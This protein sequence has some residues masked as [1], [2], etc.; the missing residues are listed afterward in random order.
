M[1]SVSLML[2]CVD[3]IVNPYSYSCGLQLQAQCLVSKV[4]KAFQPVIQ[5]PVLRI[6]HCLSLRQTLFAHPPSPSSSYTGSSLLLRAPPR[7]SNPLAIYGPTT[8]IPPTN[9]AIVAKKSPNNTNIPY[10]SMMNPKNAQRMRIS[11]IPATKASVPFHFWRRA[12][13]AT[14]LVVPMMRVRPM[15]KRIW[16]WVGGLGWIA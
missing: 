14:V 2:L 7:A 4:D 11:A 1:E 13:K 8:G 3:I 12:K 15:R 10:N 16:S 9:P 6:I 5:T